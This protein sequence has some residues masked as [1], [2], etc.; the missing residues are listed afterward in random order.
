[1]ATSIYQVEGNAVWT[2]DVTDTNLHNQGFILAYKGKYM[3]FGQ[4]GNLWKDFH[5]I[6]EQEA[7]GIL[8]MT[9]LDT[10]RSNLLP[11]AEGTLT[12]T[13]DQIGGGSG[14][15]VQVACS[16]ALV[17]PSGKMEVP[18]ARSAEIDVHFHFVSTDGAT[19]PLA[20]S[21]V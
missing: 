1:M 11:G 7:E 8:L 17:I 2:V 15:D 5:A 18:H 6:M 14:T 3:S 9:D 12:L 10:Y 19:S 21:L 4:D 20:W 16:G 13:A